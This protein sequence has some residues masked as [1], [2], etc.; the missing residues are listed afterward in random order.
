MAAKEDVVYEID[1]IIP[2]MTYDCPAFTDNINQSYPRQNIVTR[3]SQVTV[4]I[5][6]GPHYAPTM[7]EAPQLDVK[8][9]PPPGAGY[10]ACR[11]VTPSAIYRY[12]QPS[13]EGQVVKPEHQAHLDSLGEVAYD[14]PSR[15]EFVKWLEHPNITPS[16][17]EIEEGMD[18]TEPGFLLFPS[19]PDP[20]N[21]PYGYRLGSGGSRQIGGPRISKGLH[22]LGSEEVTETIPKRAPPTQM[23]SIPR[24]A[25]PADQR[26]IALAP[27]DAERLKALLDKNAT[28]VR[29]EELYNGYYEEVAGYREALPEVDEVPHRVYTAEEYML[30]Y[31]GNDGSCKMADGTIEQGQWYLA[32]VPPHN[33]KPPNVLDPSGQLRSLDLINNHIERIVRIFIPNRVLSY[34]MYRPF[35][36][37]IP[38]S[39]EFAVKADPENRVAP[40]VVQ[41][42][43]VWAR[44]WFPPQLNQKV[45]RSWWGNILVPE[46]NR[47]ELVSV[48]KP[49]ELA[50]GQDHQP[51]Y[52]G[53]P[54]PLVDP[55][56][57]PPEPQSNRRAPN[58]ELGLRF[59]SS[60][61]A[62][63]GAYYR[64]HFPPHLI[65]IHPKIS[66]KKYPLQYVTLQYPPQIIFIADNSQDILQYQ[67]RKVIQTKPIQVPIRG[68]FIK[69]D[70]PRDPDGREIKAYPDTEITLPG[71]RY[72]YLF[73]PFAQRAIQTLPPGE[74]QQ[75][76]RTRFYERTTK[77]GLMEGEKQKE[78]SKPPTT[79]LKGIGFLVEPDDM[80]Y[81]KGI[82]ETIN[83]RDGHWYRV[84][85]PFYPQVIYPGFADR[86]GTSFDKYPLQ[87]IPV[88]MPQQL[89]WIP[90][91][92]RYMAWK[93]FPNDLKVHMLTEAAGMKTEEVTFAPNSFD[94]YPMPQGRQGIHNIVEHGMSR[95]PPPLRVLRDPGRGVSVVPDPTVS[96]VDPE[97]G[98]L[99]PLEPGQ[100]EPIAPF[101]G[102]TWTNLPPYGPVPVVSDEVF[103]LREGQPGPSDSRSRY[104]THQ[105]LSQL[106]EGPIDSGSESD[107]ESEPTRQRAQSDRRD[108]SQPR[109][110]HRLSHSVSPS[111]TKKKR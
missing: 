80:E 82:P 83:E 6:S 57:P 73:M 38:P 105:N 35:T 26:A 46:E 95:L 68:T 87:A 89:V 71:R 13:D 99:G 8:A 66:G 32:F 93:I 14:D 30:R 55:V 72:S 29:A 94:F 67:R 15:L 41:V 45:I 52:L 17:S 25:N 100:D 7:L 51:T 48:S 24:R 22:G 27:R 78:R 20:D 2:P 64:V 63:A 11:T 37:Q 61:P 74:H 31:Q 54:A 34:P 111:R 75:I 56:A 97:I 85:F 76:A 106:M 62:R 60:D 21:L 81:H 47:V 19:P 84:S 3:D 50:A 69:R 40:V 108:R 10:P 36:F 86:H 53:Q 39:P 59:N 28:I 77:L 4:V 91:S 98:L 49:P 23:V 107:T 88:N 1:I 96:D 42:P 102:A 101:A 65:R 18:K 92:K 103:P 110:V 79:P 90:V 70:R 109:E 12:W 43:G 58:L 5:R 33:Y 44:F 16:L 9:Q 104:A